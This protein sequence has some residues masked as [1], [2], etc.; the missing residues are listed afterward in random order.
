MTNI[1]LFQLLI[2]ENLLFSVSFTDFGRLDVKLIFL[3]RYLT[4]ETRSQD[5]EPPTE[6]LSLLAASLIMKRVHRQI[7]VKTFKLTNT[8]RCVS[9]QSCDSGR[10]LQSRSS[11]CSPSG[12]S[13][14]SGTYQLCTDRIGSPGRSPAGEEHRAGEN[15]CSGGGAGGQVRLFVCCPHLAE[16]LSREGVTH[17]LFG[18]RLVAVT[19]PAVGVTVETGS[20]AVTLAADDVVLTSGNKE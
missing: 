1:C 2:Y 3:P 19:W 18:S 17:F 10:W 7:K 12:W 16:T 8:P 4:P 20:A 13:G 14:P 5:Q 11:W 9:F 6:S 15:V